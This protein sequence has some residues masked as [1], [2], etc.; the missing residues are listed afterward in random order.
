MAPAGPA[1]GFTGNQSHGDAQIR[2][3]G[4]WNAFKGLINGFLDIQGSSFKDTV[5]NV[6]PAHP[7]SSKSFLVQEAPALSISMDQDAVDQ[8]AF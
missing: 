3:S 5:K 4:L 8:A 1:F 7:P 6:V 2:P